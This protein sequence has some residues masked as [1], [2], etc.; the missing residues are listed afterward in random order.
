[1]AV[2]VSSYLGYGLIY[3]LEEL[4]GLRRFL[5]PEDKKILSPANM[6]R[7]DGIF[8]EIMEPL[9]YAL[10]SCLRLEVSHDQ[11]GGGFE[12]TLVIAA[13]STVMN[14]DFQTDYFRAFRYS[15]FPKPTDEEVEALAMLAD[16]EGLGPGRSP[17]YVI[18]G[19]VG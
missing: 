1:M 2:E 10:P 17:E 13:K 6:R 11:W 19:W 12:S 3:P 5:D 4:T 7:G 16:P 14:L 15:D 9:H 18:W 8:M